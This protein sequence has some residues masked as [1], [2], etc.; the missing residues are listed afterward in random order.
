[1]EEHQKKDLKSWETP[2]FCFTNTGIFHWF[3]F[4]N[5]SQKFNSKNFSLFKEISLNFLFV[6]KLNFYPSR[7]LLYRKKLDHLQYKFLDLFQFTLS[8]NVREKKSV[9]IYFSR[10]KRSEKF[11]NTVGITDQVSKR[12]VLKNEVKKDNSL[13]SVLCDIF[14][15]WAIRHTSFSVF[16]LKLWIKPESDFNF[17]FSGCMA[18]F[19]RRTVMFYRKPEKMIINIIYYKFISRNWYH[20]VSHQLKSTLIQ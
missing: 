4:T 2:W 17:P 7:T 19:D 11:T 6:F 5:T 14:P 3:C 8:K 16:A 1:M 12:I 18:F 13:R 20:I 15:F 10:S 9:K